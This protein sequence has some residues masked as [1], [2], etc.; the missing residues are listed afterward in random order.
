MNESFV[1]DRLRGGNAVGRRIRLHPWT[2]RPFADSAEPWF[3]IVGVVSDVVLDA[4]APEVGAGAYLLRAPTTRLRMAVHLPGGAEEFAGRLRAIAMQVSPALRVRHP[5]PL[6]QAAAGQTAVWD[7]LFRIIAVVGGFALLLTNAGIYAVTAFTVS[8][9]TREIGVR[10]ALGAARHDIV[11]TTLSRM[12]R[13]VA[14]GVVLGCVPGLLITFE[15]AGAP[16]EASA[17]VAG[18]ALG[19]LIVMTTICLAACIVPARRA[20]AIEPTEALAAE[21]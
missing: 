19:Y 6:D 20:L 18:V 13:R 1:Q 11:S 15:L 12:A 14:L 5:V 2:N 10:V 4:G 8:R 17:G 3:E 9:R 21:G 7:L 16:V